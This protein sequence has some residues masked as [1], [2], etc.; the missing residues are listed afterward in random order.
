MD[1]KTVAAVAF[2]GGF[3]VGMNWPKIKKFVK[4]YLEAIG[5]STTTGYSGIT[6]FLAEQKELMDDLAAEAKTKNAKEK[7][8]TSP[9]KEKGI[10]N[11]EQLGKRKKSMR[12]KR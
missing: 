7:A 11:K 5:K 3:A 6:Q 1:K 8:V 10:K 4:P 12:K 2:I 9:I